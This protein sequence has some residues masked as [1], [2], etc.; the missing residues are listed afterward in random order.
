MRRW[1]VRNIRPLLAML[2]ITGSAM[3]FA[4]YERDRA[5]REQLLRDEAMT[6][7]GRARALTEDLA[8]SA[9][10]LADL[11]QWVQKFQATAVNLVSMKDHLRASIDQLEKE[12]T[13]NNISAKDREHFK[14]ELA[15]NN[16]ELARVDGLIIDNRAQQAQ[17]QYEIAAAE[18]RVKRQASAGPRHAAQAQ[19]ETAEQRFEDANG[20]AQQRFDDGD[21]WMAE[22]RLDEACTAF[23]ESNRLAPRAGTLIRLAECR[24]QNHQLASAVAT[25]RDALARVKDPRKRAYAQ[26]QLTA[27]EPRLSYLT[28]VVPDDRRRDGLAINYDDRPLDTTL[29][30]QPQPIDGGDHVIAAQADGHK[31]WRTTAHVPVERGQIQIEVPRLVALR[32]PQPPQPVP[33]APPL[34]AR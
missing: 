12:L 24:E 2:A 18:A 17:L 9:K 21:R 20:R 5:V 3:G 11:N 1:I 25:Y 31:A 16:D 7:E 10:E 8:N 28:V 22:G 29:W 19:T 14:K 32:N 6:Q 4:V 15:K 23:E 27:L 13:A 26:Q 34:P 33:V 30:N